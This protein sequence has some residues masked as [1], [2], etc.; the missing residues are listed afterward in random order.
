[1]S[2][3]TPLETTVRVDPASVSLDAPGRL[4]TTPETQGENGIVTV[5]KESVEKLKNEVKGQIVQPG[6]SCYDEVR[7]VWNAMIDRR[8]AF[9]V[10]C[11]EANDVTA[12]LSF[13]RN[14]GLELSIRGAG[15]NIAGN[16]LNDNGLMIDFS[17]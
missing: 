7:Q 5:P 1:M 12:A 17:T 3:T 11:A 2:S 9:I 15:H 8:P 16:A 10:R 14:N 4:S 6:D 13:A